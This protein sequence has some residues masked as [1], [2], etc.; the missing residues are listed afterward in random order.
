MNNNDLIGDLNDDNQI[1]VVDV[2]IIVNI[3]LNEEFDALADLN[4]DEIIN[5]FDIILLV[6][7]ILN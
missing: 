6:N 1:N 3:I 5:I 2:I 4:E 7:I